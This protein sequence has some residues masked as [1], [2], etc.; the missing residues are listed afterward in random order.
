MPRGTPF[1]MI[2]GRG[3]RTFS[4]ES[5]SRRRNGQ[6]QSAVRGGGDLSI[7][8][9][10]SLAGPAGALWRSDQGPYRDFPAGPRAAYGRSCSRLLASDA[11]NEY[12][13]RRAAWHRC[14]RPPSSRPKKKSM[15]IS[16]HAP[17]ASITH[18]RLANARN[19]RAHNPPSFTYHL[20]EW[21]SGAIT[22]QT[23][24][25]ERNPLLC[26]RRPSSPCRSV[27]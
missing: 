20:T 6:G 25:R 3:S 23:C 17:A 21:K 8:R 14:P 1:G 22:A 24:S 19:R 7:S 26:Q 2:N 13:G 11:N 9:R 27:F 15:A 12:A 5:G 4:R 18:Q 10:H 16:P